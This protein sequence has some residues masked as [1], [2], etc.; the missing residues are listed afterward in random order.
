MPNKKAPEVVQ[1]TATLLVPI[2][3]TEFS[4]KRATD[5][6]PVNHAQDARATLNLDRWPGMVTRP[7]SPATRVFLEM[8]AQ[9]PRLVSDPRSD[10]ECPAAAG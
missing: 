5:V 2:L 1:M 4:L 3:G 7:S 6:P 9:S 10:R 8:E